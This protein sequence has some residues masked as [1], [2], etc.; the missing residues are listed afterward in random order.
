[1]LLAEVA[2]N[3]ETVMSI[4]PAALV[5]IPPVAFKLKKLH[6]NSK[7]PLPIAYISTQIQLQILQ[8][9]F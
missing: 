9:L 1:M 6:V 5:P 7:Q 4:V 8:D 2:S 3:S